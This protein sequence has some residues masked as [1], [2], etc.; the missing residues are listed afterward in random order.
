MVGETGFEPATPWSQTRCS[1][2]LS[3]SPPD[4]FRAGFLGV[5]G[6]CGNGLGARPDYSGIIPRI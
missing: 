4:D 3:Y 2:R 1:T 5:L 6:P